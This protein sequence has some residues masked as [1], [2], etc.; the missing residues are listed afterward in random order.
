MK[1]IAIILIF[2][3]P[4]ISQGQR[5]IVGDGEYVTTI[6][7]RYTYTCFSVAGNIRA[8]PGLPNTIINCAGAAHGALFLDSSHF[9]W[10]IG[11]NQYGECGNGTTTFVS[12][13]TKILVDSLGNTFDHVIQI[14][15]GAAVYSPQFGWSSAAVKDD[16][17]VWV[18]GA[19]VGGLDGNGTFGKDTCTRPTQVVF[20]AGTFIVK[21]QGTSPMIALDSAGNVWTWAANM[22]QYNAQY[23]LARGNS[24]NSF[25]PL[26]VT[27]PTR[28][29]DIAGGGQWNYA[30]LI[31][32]TVYGWG[33]YAGYLGIGYGDGGG[34]L[35][36]TPSINTFS[37]S[38]IRV[39][40]AWHLPYNVRS[41]T[42]NNNFTYMIL[43]NHSLWGMGDN[44]QG[45]AG[46]GTELNFATYVGGNGFTPYF[47]DQG[48][49]EKLQRKPQ[50]IA[51]GKIDFDTVFAA[52]TNEF[53]AYAEDS[54][55]S[56]FA[57]GRNKGG[58]I[59]NGIRECDS[60]NG[61]LTANFPNAW[62]VPWITP[63][64][65]SSG[66][67]ISTCPRCVDTTNATYCNTCTIGTITTPT[68]NLTLTQIGPT[69]F[70]ADATGSTDAIHNTYSV[71]TQIGG[72]A[73]QMRL[74][75]AWRDTI[76]NAPVGVPLTFQETVTNTK[77]QS[78]TSSPVSITLI[79]ASASNF[80]LVN[81]L[82]RIII[83]H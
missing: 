73:V 57:W 33:V 15:G 75:A 16:G 25:V 23:M 7:D 40:T 67:W 52:N 11:D 20:P 47:W 37:V 70:V 30:M 53:C 31:D 39:D 26:K 27:L 64:S 77:W 74:N 54:H 14:L 65:L 44:A 59:I 42:V 69:T 80:L 55:D 82:Q 76:Y 83:S 38:P 63:V 49:G 29:R 78:N 62:D 48:P 2:I 28:C 21:I 35:Y 81:P 50:Q 17:T 72:P 56:L 18:W 6:T 12:T 66:L 51:P 9:V 19:K 58:M 4:C 8:V 41:M 36:A 32:S 34:T 61:T 1:I 68:A 22:P 3:S 5:Y 24:P 60:L 71:L 46:V 43:G 79:S 10:A 45:N 13:A